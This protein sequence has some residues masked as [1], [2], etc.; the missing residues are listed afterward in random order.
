VNGAE[1]AIAIV[2]GVAAGGLAGVLGIGGGIIM[3]P[4]LT[5]FIHLGQRVAQGTS[6]A[7][8]VVT[9]IVGAVSAHRRGLLDGVLAVRVAIGG[10]IGAIGGALLATQVVDETLLRRLFG[11]LVLLTAARLLRSLLVSQ[12]DT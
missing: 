11:V 9:A 3:V 1:I 6:L 8:I 5:E 7:V 2:T 4:V 12:P 10:S